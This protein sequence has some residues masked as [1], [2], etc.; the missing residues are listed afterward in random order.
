MEKILKQ[1]KELEKR[2]SRMRLAAES[3]NEEW[4]TLISTIMS[5][6]TRDEKTIPIASKLFQK[7][8][9]S[10]LA[11]ANI[12]D[13]KKIIKPV[14][15]YKT[16]SKNVINCAKCL[17]NNYNSK[18]PHDFDKLIDLPGVG[19]KTANVFLAEY[20]KHALPVDTHVFYISRKLGWAKSNKPHK[21]E[22]ELKNLF[23]KE[24]WNKINEILVRFGK[25]YTSRKEKDEVLNEIKNLR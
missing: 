2:S 16:K 3:W 12:K 8:N 5:A 11:K 13:V 22:E 7:Y 18:V 25:T 10:K 17:V 14:N 24:Y 15:F 6:R 19:R 23:P 21:V 9:L 4:Q 20:G 1:L